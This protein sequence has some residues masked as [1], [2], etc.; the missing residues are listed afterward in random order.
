MEI[1]RKQLKRVDYLTVRGRV[2]GSTAPLLDAAL[3][4]GLQHGRYKIV[5]DLSG[6]EFISSAGLK[7]LISVRNQARRFNRGDLVLTNV[8]QRIQGVLE[9]TG[10]DQV[11]TTARDGVEAVGLF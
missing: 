8:P 7:T 10:L 1:E 6:V 2:D 3:R 11:F 9:L 5:V 4:E